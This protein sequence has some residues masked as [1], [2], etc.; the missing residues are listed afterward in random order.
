MT[1]AHHRSARRIAGLVLATS[2][3]AGLFVG[4]THNTASAWSTT[5]YDKQKTILFIH[6]YN[7]TSNSTNCGENFDV[8]INSLRASGYTGR[9]IRVGYYAGDTNCD[10]N[11]HW[12]GSYNDN[13]SWRN[14]SRALDR[15][16]WF[17]HTQWGETVDIVGYSMGG[18]IARG[19]VWGSQS[20]ELGSHRLQVEDVLTLGTPHNGAQG[21]SLLFC[22]N[23]QCGSLQSGSADLQ[24]LN[25][26]MNPTTA[27]PV[28][29]DFTVVGSYDDWVVAPA[30]A[31][32][33]GTF[34]HRYLYWGISHTLNGS[35]MQDARALALARDALASDWV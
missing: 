24:W 13:D 29:T 27:W 16:I 30:S 3:I 17:A 34:A 5:R 4:L 35:Y 9:M 33:M 25:R 26:N 11:L 12:W 7:A 32:F 20:G 22:F 18:L 21:W 23:P 6:G 8:M 15:Y 10:T 28:I 2:I 1:T 31:T 14:I 19:A